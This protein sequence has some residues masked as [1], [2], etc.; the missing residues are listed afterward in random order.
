MASLPASVS[1]RRDAAFDAA[2]ESALLEHLPDPARAVRELRRVLRPGGVVGL[3]DGDW[4]AGGQPVL[5][6]PDPLVE[7]AIALW[8]RV[9]R[10]TG[11]DPCLGRRHRTLLHG[12]GFTGVEASA[13]A[14][15]AG[16]AEA[17]RRLGATMTRRLLEDAAGTEA[18]ARGWADRARLETLAAAC[19]AW[20]EHPGAF[21]AS[22]WCTA[23]GWAP[24]P[25][26]PGTRRRGGAG[27]LALTGG[28]RWCRA[29]RL[30]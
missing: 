12:A 29:R 2:F 1:G 15:A 19:R 16:T 21:S 22:F 23:V 20:G 3:R 14:D 24:G 18:I 26:P 25:A 17:A 13:T 5:E 6:P 11:A 28:P 30:G 27:T 7:E 9:W 8:A 10:R 4:G